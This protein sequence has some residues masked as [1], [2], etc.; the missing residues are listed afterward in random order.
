MPENMRPGTGGQIAPPGG[1]MACSLLSHFFSYDICMDDEFAALAGKRRVMPA[2]IKRLASGADLPVGMSA[3][4]WVY[5]RAHKIHSTP[6]CPKCHTPLKFKNWKQGYAGP[7]PNRNCELRRQTALDKRKATCLRKYGVEFI[8]QSGHIRSKIRGSCLKKYGVSNPMKSGKVKAKFK[9]TCISRYAVS[10][11]SKDKSVQQKKQRTLLRN[12]GVTTPLASAYIKDKFRRTCMRKFDASSPLGNRDIHAK[13]MR[14][15]LQKTYGELLKKADVVIPLFDI[16][17]FKGTNHTTLY[18]WKCRICGSMFTAAYNSC[19]IPVCRH[20]HPVSKPQDELSD[21]IRDIY[22]GKI[23]INDR[24]VISPM[25]LDIYLPDLKLAFEFNGVKWHSHGHLKDSEYHLRKTMACRNKGIRLIHI[26]EHEWMKSREFAISRVSSALLSPETDG[27]LQASKIYRQSAIEFA[28][29]HSPWDIEDLDI[30]YGIKDGG[31]INGILPVKRVHKGA[32]RLGRYVGVDISQKGFLAL[33][34]AF[35]RDFKPDMLLALQDLACQTDEYFKALG[36][37]R[38]EFDVHPMPWQ[39]KYSTGFARRLRC[40]EALTVQA[41]PP[42]LG[43]YTIYDC[44][45]AVWTK[46]F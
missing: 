18:P 15:V 21:Y 19:R 2:T 5:R 27:E 1:Q 13:G 35:I 6:S 4:E 39:V 11:P 24:T 34:D 20:C 42:R 8:S 40:K 32:Y 38:M 25:E 9:Q 17:Q 43:V 33:T 28:A 31:D 44:G 7:C 30:C 14:A 26:W 41:N 23:K 12:Y 46:R 29:K 3:L 10:N 37:R 45:Y 16:N 22:P 36:M